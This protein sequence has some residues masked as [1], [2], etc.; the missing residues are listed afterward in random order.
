[1]IVEAI[2]SLPKK[3]DTND[4]YFEN[5]NIEIIINIGTRSLS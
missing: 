5:K 1:M 4:V 3:S 2:K